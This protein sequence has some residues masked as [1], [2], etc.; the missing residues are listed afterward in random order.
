MCIGLLPSA[1]LLMAGAFALEHG[2]ARELW[3]F[4]CFISVICCFIA[5]FMLFARKTAAAVLGGLVLL[6]LNGFVAFFS[7][8]T[9]TLRF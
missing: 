3:A 4:V 6:L 7:G 5:S 2:T 1:L 8:C 9:A